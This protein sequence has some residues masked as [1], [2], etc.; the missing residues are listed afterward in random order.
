MLRFDGAGWQAMTTPVDE[1]LLSIWGSA[2]DNV[3]AVGR[4]GTILHYD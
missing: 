4:A 3:F 1:T 2:G